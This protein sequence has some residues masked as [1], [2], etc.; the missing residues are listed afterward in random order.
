MRELP[1]DVDDYRDMQQGEHHPEAAHEAHHT[2]TVSVA[3]PHHADTP[4]MLSVLVYARGER[5]MYGGRRQA[6][7]AKLIFCKFWRYFVVLHIIVRQ[8]I[9]QEGE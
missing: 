8:N 2:G 6:Q 4:P 7:Y 3:E 5:S 9:L 1:Q